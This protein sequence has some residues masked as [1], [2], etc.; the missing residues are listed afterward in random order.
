MKNLLLMKKFAV[1]PGTKFSIRRVYPQKH[2][3]LVIFVQLLKQNLTEKRTRGQEEKIFQTA[4]QEVL[5]FSQGYICI[6][7]WCFRK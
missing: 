3:H 7:T 1:L 4:C 6:S 2:C 5:L